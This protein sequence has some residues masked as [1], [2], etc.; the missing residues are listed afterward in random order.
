VAGVNESRKSPDPA[1]VALP[2][3]SG[4]ASALRERLDGLRPLLLEVIDDSARHA[5]HAGAAGGG[6]H[7]RL[8]IV[9]PDFIGMPTLARHRRIYN[10]LGELMRGKIHALSIRALDPE[11]AR[12]AGLLL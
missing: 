8:L 12:Q 5:G 4:F 1:P 3:P 11:E 7:Y 9:A 10:T 6:G 2:P